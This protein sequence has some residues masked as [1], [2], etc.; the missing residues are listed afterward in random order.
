MADYTIASSDLGVYE[1]QLAANTAVTV[2]FETQITPVGVNAHVTVHSGTSP[3]YARAGSA[4]TN[5][6]SK[7]TVIDPRTWATVALS[8]RDGAS[9]SIIS[10]SSAVVSVSRM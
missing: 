3:V 5:R 8:D 4:V 1:I 9:V 10:A 6:D 2:A 7:A